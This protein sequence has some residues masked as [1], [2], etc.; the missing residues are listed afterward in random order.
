MMKVIDISAW[1]ENVDWQAVREA[2]IEGVILKIGEHSHL[3]DMFVDHINKA[4]EN[5][6]QFGV[7]YFAHACTYDE[8]VAE[9]DQVAAWLKEYLRGETP[10]LGIWYDAESERMLNGDVTECCR[11]FLNRMTDYGHQYNGVYASWNWLSAEGAHHIHIEDLPNYTPYWVANY[12]SGNTFEEAC[13]DYLKAEYPDN[14]I[15]M[16]Q[17]TDNLAGFGYDASIYYDE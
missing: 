6:L 1:Q 16:H 4:V 12:G 9:A 11:A 13:P 2:G 5:G 7:Y 17:F 3:D 8:A 14:I 15:R 10:P